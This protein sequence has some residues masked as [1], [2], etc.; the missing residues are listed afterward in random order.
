VDV[1]SNQS[2][3][4]ARGGRLTCIDFLRGSAAL[5][6]VFLHSANKGQWLQTPEMTWAFGL[7]HQ[8]RLGV[9]LFFVISGFCI[10]LR[11]A[12]RQAARLAADSADATTTNSLADRV[13]AR[14]DAWKHEPTTTRSE[15]FS[16]WKRRMHRLYPPY[17]VTLCLCMATLALVYWQSGRA[18]AGTPAYPEP[19]WRWM[20]L[21]FVA[22]VTMLHGLHPELDY[23]GGNVVFWT[24]AREEY[25]YLLY[26]P[27]L[28]ARR[29]FGLFKSLAAVFAAGLLVPWG[30]YHL[31]HALSLDAGTFKVAWY[32]FNNSTSAVALW[33]QWCLGMAAVESYYGLITLPTWCRRLW[34][35]ALWAAVASLCIYFKVYWLTP[36]LWGMTFFT[37]VNYCVAR[38]HQGHWPVNGITRRVAW[39]GHLFL[40]AVSHSLPGLAG[41]AKSGDHGAPETAAPRV[42]GCVSALSTRRVGGAGS[43]GHRR[44]LGLL[45]AGGALVSQ[46]GIGAQWPRHTAGGNFCRSRRHRTDRTLTANY[47]LQFSSRRALQ[48]TACRGRGF[49]SPSSLRRLFEYSQGEKFAVSARESRAFLITIARQALAGAPLHVSS[50]CGVAPRGWPGYHEAM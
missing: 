29:Y 2:A 39:C 43:N 24:L 33:I 17:L 50:V 31:L 25:F 44:G 32:P 19:V 6:V 36:V 38:E 1:I 16:F 27:L 5:G 42:A 11:W 18:L 22:H 37:L 3:P 41:A 21:D 35:A 20:L 10:H 15:F 12:K 23:R 49:G 46:P 26:F 9:P 8:G 13:L 48:Q 34:M 30:M 47:N 7:L 4:P 14:R 45:H 40:L 28:A